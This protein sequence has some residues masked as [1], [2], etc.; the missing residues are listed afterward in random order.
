M[1]S[2]EYDRGKILL[3]LKERFDRSKLTPYNITVWTLTHR[4]IKLSD[5]FCLLSN[6]GNILAA[7][8]LL[9]PMFDCIMRLFAIQLSD[10]AHD[11][12][13]AFLYGD[14][15]SDVKI[16]N[17][18][19]TRFGDDEEIRLLDNRVLWLMD[20]SGWYR[21]MDSFYKK[22]SKYIHFSQL[23]YA[24]LFRNVESFSIGGY[25]TELSEPIIKDA[26]EDFNFLQDTFI[27]TLRYC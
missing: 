6:S 25:D 7:L 5:G 18:W 1:S 19:P 2:V 14:A 3:L 21:N 17:R 8:H 9:R 16:K 4:F 10:D 22:A 11:I 12:S 23:H 24:S 27:N 13:E 15:M 26:V 20:H